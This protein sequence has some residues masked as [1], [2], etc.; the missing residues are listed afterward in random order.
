M[1]RTVPGNA[2]RDNFTTLRNQIAQPSNILMID[3]RDLIGTE[4]TDFLSQEAF[5]SP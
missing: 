5:P 2:P 3:Q 4:S 1:P